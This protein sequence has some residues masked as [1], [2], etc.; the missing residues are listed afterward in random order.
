MRVTK[1]WSEIEKSGVTSKNT[2]FAC[3]FFTFMLKS[4]Q[5]NMLA[6]AISKNLSH[7]ISAINSLYFVFHLPIMNIIMQANVM[8]YLEIVIPIVMFDFI[9][10][11]P[12]I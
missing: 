11:I 8:T 5:I 10:S 2:V 4:L 7:L 1:F 6:A 3:L 9:E 12:F